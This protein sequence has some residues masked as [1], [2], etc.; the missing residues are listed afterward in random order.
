MPSRTLA[1]LQN[2]GDDELP[3]SIP[4]IAL[5]GKAVQIPLAYLGYRLGIELLKPE[6]PGEAPLHAGTPTHYG[7]PYDCG[8]CPDHE[9]HSCLT[10]IE[11]TD[12]CNLTCRPATPSRRRAAAA[13][14]RSRRWRRCST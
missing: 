6:P 1:S 8:L 14:A 9:Q 5:G 10:L 2:I 3:T 7:C 11:V 12:R 4:P 13:T